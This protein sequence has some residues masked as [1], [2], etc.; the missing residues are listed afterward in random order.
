MKTSQKNQ[1]IGVQGAKIHTDHNSVTVTHQ[2]Q[3]DSDPQDDGDKTTYLSVGHFY[4]VIAGEYVTS[5]Y[6]QN[7]PVKENGVNAATSEALLA[8]LIH[9]TKILNHN[10]P[11]DEN[12]CAISYMENALALFE[13]RTKDCRVSGVKGQNIA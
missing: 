5:I 6:F 1:V 8:I 12:K 4:D 7:G 10:F 3:I 11:C 9:C 13:Q 2:E